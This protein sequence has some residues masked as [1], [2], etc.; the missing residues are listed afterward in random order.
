MWC[1][2]LENTM[3]EPVNTKHYNG[4]IN[5]S[6][7]WT[8]ALLVAQVRPPWWLN[9]WYYLFLADKTH[10]EV[11]HLV[12]SGWF[13]QCLLLPGH[14]MNYGGKWP[15]QECRLWQLR[16]FVFLVCSSSVKVNFT[17]Q[18]YN[19]NIPKICLRC[20]S[21]ACGWCYTMSQHLSLPSVCE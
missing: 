11:W 8:A 17:F 15:L 7:H 1:A 4:L 9:V 16:P 2:H 6:L 14:V 5:V 13:W 12:A 10:Y 3:M 20:P 18:G 19:Y 21:C